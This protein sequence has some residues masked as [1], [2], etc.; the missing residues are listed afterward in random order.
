MMRS[1]IVGWGT[2]PPITAEPSQLSLQILRRQKYEILDARWRTRARTEATIWTGELLLKASACW[3]RWG[4]L[5]IVAKL[6]TRDVEGTPLRK[7]S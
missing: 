5:W 7:K 4:F 6:V 3:V 2:G 1:M